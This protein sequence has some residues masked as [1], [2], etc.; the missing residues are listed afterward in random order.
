LMLN[1]MRSGVVV[2]ASFVGRHCVFVLFS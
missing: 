1:N 2:T